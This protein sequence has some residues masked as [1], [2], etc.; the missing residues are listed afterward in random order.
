[1]AGSGRSST[2]WAARRACE[3]ET[4][5]VPVPSD[6]PDQE[7]SSGLLHV[8]VKSPD[9]RAVGRA[10]SSAAIELAL[11]NY[12]GFFA[13]RSAG[14]GQCLRRVL[15]GAGAGRRD[16]A[17]RRAR[18]RHAGAR[19]PGADRTAAGRRDRGAGA[20]RGRAAGDRARDPARTA[21]R[22][23]LRRQ[24]RQRQP[25][26]V[27]PRR[28]RL[29]LAGRQPDRRAGPGAAPRGRRPGGPPL[30]AGQPAGAELRARRLPRRGR[31]QL[32]RRSTRRPRGS[33]STSAPD[34]V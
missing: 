1:M 4:R 3:M 27:G 26:R 6:G 34:R 23:P 31:R 20:V 12:P 15:A 30:R 28:R 32:D 24:G 14:P 22:R 7:R 8:S 21:L 11:A 19:R 10:F 25:R 2:T 33:A 13:H 16:R 9:E 18:R 17:G 5:F 29:R